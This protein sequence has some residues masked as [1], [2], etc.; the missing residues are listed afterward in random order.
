[1][2]SVKITVTNSSWFP[3][4]TVKTTRASGVR[5]QTVADG[6]IPLLMRSGQEE[7]R[8]GMV[9]FISDLQPQISLSRDF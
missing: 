4:V 8:R 6:W 9:H 5:F 7:L 2:G 1:M 3:I